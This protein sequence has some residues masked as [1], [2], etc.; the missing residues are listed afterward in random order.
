MAGLYHYSV[1]T[2]NPPRLDTEL[3]ENS[4]I[5]T[6]R[7]I[8]LVES[9]L[10][11]SKPEKVIYKQNAE[12]HAE[13]SITGFPKC[14]RDPWFPTTFAKISQTL[15]LE[16]LHP[17]SYLFHQIFPLLSLLFSDFVSPATSLLASR[18]CL[19][20]FSLQCS[21]PQISHIWCPLTI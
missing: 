4:M 10:I 15:G 5:H 3:R 11:I 8:M 21:S 18:L 14:F 12:D 7:C 13:R 9:L 2:R 16:I 1:S 20:P 17:L 6:S 19:P